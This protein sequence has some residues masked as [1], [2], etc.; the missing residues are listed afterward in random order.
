MKKRLI[1]GMFAPLAMLVTFSVQHAETVAH[2]AAKAS[3][4][5]GKEA[6]R[7][8]QDKPLRAALLGLSSAALGAVSVDA[9]DSINFAARETQDSHRDSE[10]NGIL[11]AYLRGAANVCKKLYG[12]DLF[13][14][15]SEAEGTGV[16]I[17]DQPPPGFVPLD[18]ND[19]RACG[20]PPVP[21]CDGCKPPEPP[22]P[23]PV[24]ASNKPS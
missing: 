23:P 3:K 1:P 19:P 17:G 9:T 10:R 16:A 24:D 13:G 8:A 22:Q 6:V 4:Q 7:I 5:L 11:Q 15:A 12:F 14:G 2:N 21:P 20:V 18:P